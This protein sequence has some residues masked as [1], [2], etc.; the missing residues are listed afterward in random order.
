MQKALD[1]Y[2]EASPNILRLCAKEAKHSVA[3]TKPGG[4][5][6]WEG[7]SV[8]P[9]VASRITLASLRAAHHTGWL[10]IASRTRL[11]TGTGQGGTLRQLMRT[12]TLFLHRAPRGT[13]V[14]TFLDASWSAVGLT[15]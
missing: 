2:H 6:Q 1:R 14:S 12:C 15:S 7:Y 5:L 11:I 3:F 13:Q 9:D 4:G 8:V 10:I